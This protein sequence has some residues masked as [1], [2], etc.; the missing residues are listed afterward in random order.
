MKSKYQI[1]ID[2]SDDTSW[3]YME[4]DEAEAAVLKAFCD[5]ANASKGRYGPTFEMVKL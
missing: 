3:V 1:C 5:E 4:L 2:S